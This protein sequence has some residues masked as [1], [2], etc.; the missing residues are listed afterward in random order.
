[1]RKIVS[2]ILAVLLAASVP[3]LLA[4]CGGKSEQGYTYKSYTTS[5]ATNWNSHT[6]ETNADSEIVGYLSSPLVDVSVLDS[7]KGEYQWV[8]EAA[9]SVSDVTAENSADLVRYGCSV[10]EG[11]AD[12]GYVF[13]IKLN[14]NAKWENGEGITAE[15]YIESMK[16]LLAPEMKNYRANLYC[17]GES[18]IAG[19]EEYYNLDNE[20]RTET[21]DQA[22]EI[23]DKIINA[24]TGHPHFRIIDNSTDFDE[25]MRRLM[26][27]ISN[28]LGEPEPLEIERKFLIE[29]PNIEFLES[30][31]S[32]EKVD[33]VQTYLRSSN[34]NEEVRVRQRG[35]N[36]SYTYTK[37][38]KIKIDGLKRVELEERITENERFDVLSSRLGMY[39]I[40]DNKEGK[41]LSDYEVVELHILHLHHRILLFSFHMY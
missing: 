7:K 39:T 16:R 32:C 30:L 34:P 31:S 15:D 18:A 36:G 24:W 26:K 23:D 5:L 22:A 29:K 17:T 6:W 11:G 33:I 10:P 35:I 8:Y 20:A 3:L 27:E 28:V 13:E 12:S 19:A 40:F 37:T 1:M 25:K 21:A 14:K 41:P 38:R 9:E 2:F 4:A